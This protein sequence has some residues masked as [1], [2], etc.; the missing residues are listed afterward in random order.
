MQGGT[1]TAI[2]FDNTKQ[3]ILC[4][5]DTER[6][7]KVGKTQ[8]FTAAKISTVKHK[9]YNPSFAS[10]KG[11]VPYKGTN[12]QQK[13]K[14]QRGKRGGRDKQ[15]DSTHFANTASLLAPTSYTVAHYDPLGLINC[16]ATDT[17]ITSSFGSGPFTSFNDAMILADEIGTPKSIG[18]VKCLE[19]CITCTNLQRKKGKY[20]PQSPMIK[21]VIL[22][23]SDE[24]KES[25]STEMPGLVAQMPPM[26]L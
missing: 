13:K 2:T 5:W 23:S 6:A 3:T 16:I 20:A 19:E 22:L 15:G 10:Q 25:D 24:D 21:H 7:K 26:S 9:P 11:K 14:N 8:S 17:P 1:I 18:N 12:P 4:Y